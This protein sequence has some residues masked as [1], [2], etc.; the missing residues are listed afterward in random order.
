MSGTGEQ[1]WAE[2][3]LSCQG[4]SLVCQELEVQSQGDMVH[5]GPFTFFALNF[6]CHSGTSPSHQT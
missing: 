5:T 4:L 1:L 6:A 2:M 3:G